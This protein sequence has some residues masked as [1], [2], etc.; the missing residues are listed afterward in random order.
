MF[1][2]GI[3]GFIASLTDESFPVNGVGDREGWI[4]V[5]CLVLMSLNG[6]GGC[7]VY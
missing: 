1:W 3:F 7:I 6:L 5:L 2:L 4:L